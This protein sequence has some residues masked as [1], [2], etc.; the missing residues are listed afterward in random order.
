MR[1]S[2]AIEIGAFDMLHEEP[3]SFFLESK[4]GF[5]LIAAKRISPDELKRILA[6]DDP[7]F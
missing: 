1:H 4:D 6:E 5:P 2:E 7:F 3:F